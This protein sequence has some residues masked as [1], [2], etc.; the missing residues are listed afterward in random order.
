MCI[1]CAIRKGVEDAAD[2]WAKD[3]PDTGVSDVI[4]A[5]QV[6]RDEMI[7][8]KVCMEIEA[9]SEVIAPTH[10]MPDRAQ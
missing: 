10:A 8:D 5:L 1:V 6:V 7:V 9:E 4:Y 2:K 3:H